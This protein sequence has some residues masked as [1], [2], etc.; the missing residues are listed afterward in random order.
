VASVKPAYMAPSRNHNPLGVRSGGANSLTVS[1]GTCGLNMLIN[2]IMMTTAIKNGVTTPRAETMLLKSSIN[3]TT[4]N[5]TIMSVPSQYGTPKHSLKAEPAPAN[6]M[7]AMPY[8]KKTN[9][10]SMI[11]PDTLPNIVNIGAL[12]DSA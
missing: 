3:V 9:K 8:R 7:T 10:S 5:I 1:I 2:A 11:V 12:C 4:M 6:M